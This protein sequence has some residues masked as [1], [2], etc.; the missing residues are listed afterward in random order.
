VIP[1]PP[2]RKRREDIAPLAA[3]FL[4]HATEAAGRGP[5]SIDP[6]A[7]AL[8]ERYAWPGNAR[9]L[10]NALERAVVIAEGD[11]VTPLDLPERVRAGGAVPAPAARTEIPADVDSSADVGS[12]KERVERFE[13]NT[14]IAVLRETD[15]NQTKAARLLDVPLRTLQHKIKSY[16][17]R[18]Q[19]GT[20][21]DA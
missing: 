13:R 8:L 9:E 14:I 17:L 19:Y 7:L 3:R 12:L 18:K 6:E 21:D 10:R 2:L 5:M 16:G 15:G 11:V 4:A 20:D 1:I